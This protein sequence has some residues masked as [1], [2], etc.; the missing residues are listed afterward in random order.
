MIRHSLDC[1]LWETLTDIF[2]TIL[3]VVLKTD[4]LIKTKIESILEPEFVN[5]KHTN[6]KY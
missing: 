5:D 4:E 1:H 6:N 3:H 2:Y